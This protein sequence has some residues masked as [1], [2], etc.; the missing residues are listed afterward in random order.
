MWQFLSKLTVWGLAL[1]ASGLFITALLRH[2]SDVV[3]PLLE[4]GEKAANLGPS[5]WNTAAVI[6]TTLVLCYIW[7]DGRKGHSE[8]YGFLEEESPEGMSNEQHEG[9]HAPL[10]RIEDVMMDHR[11]NR[12][13]DLPLDLQES[14]RAD[15]EDFAR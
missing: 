4:M 11:V 9:D 3:A 15:T 14:V 8:D 1:I 5:F 7:F 6:L 12:I 2:G 10:E 13:S